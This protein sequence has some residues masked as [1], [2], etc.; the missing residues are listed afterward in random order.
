MRVHLVSDSH[1]NL[2]SIETYVRRTRQDPPD[3]ILHAGDIVSPFAAKALLNTGVTIQAVFGNNDGEET[4]LRAAFD[5][6]GQITRPIPEAVP[7]VRYRLQSD[8]LAMVILDLGGI[9]RERTAHRSD[10][11]TVGIRLKV[12][13]E[14]YCRDDGNQHNN[15][16]G[17]KHRNPQSLSCSLS[18]RAPCFCFDRFCSSV[19][20]LKF[21]MKQPSLW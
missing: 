1:D 6:A 13:E 20:H 2:R 21:V 16:N 17:G 5:G 4:G 9:P 15:A 18:A 12:L 14:D 8:C 19:R 3:L 10:G 11:Q 7:S